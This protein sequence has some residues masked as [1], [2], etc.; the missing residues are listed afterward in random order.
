MKS[1]EVPSE[2][3]DVELMLMRKTLKFLEDHIERTY[4]DL[5]TLDNKA[6]AN[7]TAAALFV[8]FSTSFQ[9]LVVSKTVTPLYWILLAVALGF[10]AL[11]L[12]LSLVVIL[13]VEYHWPV[14]A[15]WHEVTGYWLFKTEKDYIKQITSDYLLAIELNQ[16]A[17]DKKSRNFR[18]SGYVFGL[19]IVDLVAM[20]LIKLGS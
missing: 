4:R 16:N 6:R 18:I 1:P 10:F 13:P 8:S 19:I 14:A 3:D 5:D 11:M 17:V 12:I 20:F 15:K 2:T 7:I 9:L